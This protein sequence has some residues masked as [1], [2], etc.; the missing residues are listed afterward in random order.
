MET[1]SITDSKGASLLATKG[2]GT[3]N[4]TFSTTNAVGPYRLEVHM[5]AKV[6][7]I[8]VH[9]EFKDVILP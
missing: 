6:V 2:T 1:V 4:S 3:L 7:D 9:F 5:P 8:T